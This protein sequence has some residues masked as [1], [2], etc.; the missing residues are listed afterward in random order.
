M[1]FR[2]KVLKSLKIAVVG[3]FCFCL[4]SF[5][6]GAA[7]SSGT[8]TTPIYYSPLRFDFSVLGTTAELTP[9][10]RYQSGLPLPRDSYESVSDSGSVV[11]SSVN[12]TNFGI[13]ALSSGSVLDVSYR[14]SFDVNQDVDDFEMVV[15]GNNGFY[16]FV[17]YGIPQLQVPVNYTVDVSIS[18]DVIFTQEQPSFP[19]YDQLSFSR[20]DS[21][22]GNI[23]DIDLLFN[24]VVVGLTE[25]EIVGDVFISNYKATLSFTSAGSSPGDGEYGDPGYYLWNEVLSAPTFEEYWQG[26]GWSDAPIY[27]DGVTVFGLV[28]DVVEELTI[29]AIFIT[30]VDG[31]SEGIDISYEFTYPDEIILAYSSYD[32]GWYSYTYGEDDSNLT[33]TSL[34]LRCFKFST[35]YNDAFD[36]TG[37]YWD[38]DIGNGLESYLNYVAEFSSWFSDNN[39]YFP[40][41]PLLEVTSTD[42]QTTTFSDGDGGM[43]FHYYVDRAAAQQFDSALENLGD[44]N[45][46]S[47]F[48]S[49][50]NSGVGFIPDFTGWLATA[51]SG[52]VDAY[53][54]PNFSISNMIVVIISIPLTLL[55]L[56]YFAGG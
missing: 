10:I 26:A 38:P 8:N 42:G 47:G 9:T 44:M 7:Y 36:L 39:E 40:D 54:F 55:F 21:Y 11:I 12:R 30:D 17:K 51:V 15:T 53:I 52:F 56:K 37:E 4:I 2:S 5:S 50:Q 35:R 43:Y 13:S 32:G 34:Q 27:L 48:Y 16:N 33:I 3:L 46:Q 25:Y 41:N 45:W 14:L 49:G 1:L 29:A 6:V 23:R 24:Y 20:T 28:D 31:F 18:Y 22:A 19:Q